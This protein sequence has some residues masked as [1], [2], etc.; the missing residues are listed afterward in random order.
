M[1][2]MAGAVD[3]IVL[4]LG[5]ELMSMSVYVLAGFDRFSPLVERKRRLKYFLIGAFAS[6][7]L[8]YR[9]CPGLRRHWRN[10]P[11]PDR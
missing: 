1:L 4:F 3:L 9:H 7:F 10:Q 11:D 2:F 8:L 6:A 5:L